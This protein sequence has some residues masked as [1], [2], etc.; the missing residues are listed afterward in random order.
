MTPTTPETAPQLEPSAPA[1]RDWR[2]TAWA[3]ILIAA[4]GLIPGLIHLQEKQGFALFARLFSHPRRPKQDRTPWEVGNRAKVAL[5]LITMDYG[6]LNCASKQ[7]FGDAHCR[8][9]DKR[10][11]WPQ[12]LPTAGANQ[13]DLIQPYRTLIGNRLLL[14]VGLWNEPAIALRLHR[15]SPAGMIEKDLTRFVAD[16]EVQFVGVMSKPN[17]QWAHGGKWLP[18]QDTPVAIPHNCTI[19]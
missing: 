5:T 18:D 4:V 15:E 6:R 13:R 7:T 3:A 2:R 14:V 9:V 17:L 8:Y 16:C 11:A 19:R 10:H 12:S 1:F